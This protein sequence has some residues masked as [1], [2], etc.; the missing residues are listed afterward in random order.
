MLNN[1]A[2]AFVIFATEFEVFHLD[3]AFVCLHV[4][5]VMVSSASWWI[6]NCV[7]PHSDKD[8]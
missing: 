3:W 7:F 5:Q 6:C 4:C 8:N 2:I 1:S